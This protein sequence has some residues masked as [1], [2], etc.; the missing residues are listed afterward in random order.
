[1]QDYLSDRLWQS[2]ADELD[3]WHERHL[4]RKS[5]RQLE[6]EAV[7]Q[8][9][10][11]DQL[12][13]TVQQLLTD[14]QAVKTANVSPSSFLSH[15]LLTFLL[16]MKFIA[17]QCSTQP[18]QLLSCQCLGNIRTS[19]MMSVWWLQ[20]ELVRDTQHEAAC[21]NLELQDLHSQLQLAQETNVSL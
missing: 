7:V 15:A 2:Q 18:C 8:Q 12:D 5:I 4:L 1:M 21:A 17:K 9:E 10:T 16:H 13:S 3:M 20:V 14:L 11:S 6:A 19:V